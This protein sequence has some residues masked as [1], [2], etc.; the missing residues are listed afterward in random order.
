[1]QSYVQGIKWFGIELNDA[2]YDVN[3][4]SG[5]LVVRIEIKRPAVS[6]FN[7]LYSQT[8]HVMM[9]IM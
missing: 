2:C 5:E 4:V 8:M 3:D 1:M 7:S 9:L 6:Q